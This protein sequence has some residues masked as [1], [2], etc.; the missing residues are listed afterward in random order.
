M[1]FCVF[2]CVCVCGRGGDTAGHLTP[3]VSQWWVPPDLGAGV[4]PMCSIFSS[5][6]LP[7]SAW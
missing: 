5:I 6:I 3:P 1:C 2:V 7:V 4:L